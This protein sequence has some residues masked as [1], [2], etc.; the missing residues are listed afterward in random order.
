MVDRKPKSCMPSCPKYARV[1]AELN[2]TVCLKPQF[3]HTAGTAPVQNSHSSA[4]SAPISAQCHARY[5]EHTVWHG[6]GIASGHEPGVTEGPA[7]GN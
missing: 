2:G 1:R 7:Q 6:E 3:G 5:I 4:R